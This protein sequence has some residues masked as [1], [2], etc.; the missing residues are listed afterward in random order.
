M[1]KQNS[2]IM[3]TPERGSDR[4]IFC[5]SNNKSALQITKAVSHEIRCSNSPR[6]RKARMSLQDRPRGINLL[7]SG[8]TETAL[9]RASHQ[10]NKIYK[11]RMGNGTSATYTRLCMSIISKPKFFL[12]VSHHKQLDS[13]IKVKLASLSLSFWAT[14]DSNITW[15]LESL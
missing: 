15:V 6:Q 14:E 13:I 9:H 8:E 4:K 1:S 2:V 11:E 3:G 7:R 12:T 10:Q 5:I